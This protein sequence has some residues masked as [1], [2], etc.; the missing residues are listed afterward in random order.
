M[1]YASAEVI[2]MQ[3]FDLD[4]DFEILMRHWHV[5]TDFAAAARADYQQLAA[6]LPH[7]SEPVRRAQERWRAAERERRY[8]QRAIAELEATEFS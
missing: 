4:T 7:W 5:T 2:Q 3:A 6:T 8:L 1:V